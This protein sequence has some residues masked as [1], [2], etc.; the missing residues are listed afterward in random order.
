MKI[1]KKGFGTKTIH[2]GHEK[3]PF[4]TLATPIYQSSTFVFDTAE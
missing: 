1:D 2:E 4:G 3:N